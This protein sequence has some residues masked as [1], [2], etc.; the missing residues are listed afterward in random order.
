MAN[1]AKRVRLF[2]SQGGSTLTE[3]L[4]TIGIVTGLMGVGVLSLS[5]GYLTLATAKQN[6]V[7]DLRRARMQAT[8][9]GAHYR[10]ESSGNVYTISRLADSDGD[11]QWEVDQNSSAKVVELPVGFSVAAA[12]ESGGGYYA[13]FDSRGLLVPGDDGSLGI[14][15]V[16]LRDDKGQ[17]ERLHIWPS[18]QVEPTSAGTTQVS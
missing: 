3:V 6:L 4:V 14:I 13:E 12:S 8:L 10:F 9:K 18:G 1:S 2:A 17:L 15:S 5:R 7:N 11:G 16:V